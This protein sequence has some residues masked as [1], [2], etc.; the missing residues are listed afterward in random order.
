MKSFSLR[1]A[2]LSDH[3]PVEAAIA[4]CFET[5]VALMDAA[6]TTRAGLRALEAHL[7]EDRHKHARWRIPRRVKTGKNCPFSTHIDSLE[8]VDWL[9]AKRSAEIDNAARCRIAAPRPGLTAGLFHGN[10]AEG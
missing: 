9:I 7:R 1:P 3:I 6:P 5:E 10:N 2:T 8:G 4:A